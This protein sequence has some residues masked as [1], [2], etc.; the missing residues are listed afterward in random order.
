MVPIN[1]IQE[2]PITTPST[3][4]DINPKILQTVPDNDL[5]VTKPC[6]DKDLLFALYLC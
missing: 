4:P 6:I 1:S 5:H 2:E 3:S